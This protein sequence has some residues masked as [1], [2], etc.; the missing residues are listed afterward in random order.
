MGTSIAKLGQRET[1]VE[2]D[3]I[4]LATLDYVLR[5]VRARMVRIAFDL[6]LASMYAG[7]HAADTPRLGI[8]AHAI[9]DLEA[10]RHGRSIRCH[11]RTAKKAVPAMNIHSGM[12]I[13]TAARGISSSKS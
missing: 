10:L 9:M 11:R 12:S 1:L 7:D 4:R 2:G 5:I 8:P 6:E 13:P 3:M